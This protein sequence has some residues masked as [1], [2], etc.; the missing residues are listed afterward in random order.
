ME[1]NKFLS[2]EGLQTLVN[3]I[4]QV[5]ATKSWVSSTYA[6]IKDLNDVRNNTNQVDSTKYATKS[7]LNNKANK[8]HTHFASDIINLESVFP[9][10]V[11]YF[12]R[13]NESRFPQSLELQ[14][15]NSTITYIIEHD[16]HVVN[17]TGLAFT[18]TSDLMEEQTYRE[19]LANE[20]L[21][22]D[23]ATAFLAIKITKIQSSQTSQEVM[24][25][26]SIQQYMDPHAIMPDLPL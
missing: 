19:L 16:A 2:L 8:T 7:E 20:E 18:T 25:V 24:L 3:Q 22:I 5:F 11:I 21:T 15:I 23:P 10:S 9:P 6:T 13:E 4:Y 1:N 26:S 12:S 17:E 14:P